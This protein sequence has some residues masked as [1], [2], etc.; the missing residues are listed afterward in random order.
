M[1]KNA[2][3]SDT[4]PPIAPPKSS[5]ALVI[6]PPQSILVSIPT[7]P[8]STLLAS[9]LQSRV[10]TNPVIRFSAPERI[11]LSMEVKLLTTPTQSILLMNFAISAPICEKSM[12][13]NVSETKSKAF[14]TAVESVS[15]SIPQSTA[16][17]AL[18]TELPMPFARLLKSKL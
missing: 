17:N 14:F 16:A 10:P 6:R 9:L 18:L 15:P 12:D 11:L 1:R 7:K 2:P 3:R 5:N 8:F 4:A 13:L